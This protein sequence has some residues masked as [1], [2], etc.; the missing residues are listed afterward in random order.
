MRNGD[1]PPKR[2]TLRVVSRN[3]ASKINAIFEQEIPATDHDLALFLRRAPAREAV[4]ETMLAGGTIT[5][6]RVS[7]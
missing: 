2:I 6:E 1:T 3:S 7:K 5:I 4:A